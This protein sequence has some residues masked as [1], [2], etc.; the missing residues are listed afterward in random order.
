MKL[1]I[2]NAFLAST[3][4]WLQEM[5]RQNE[6]LGKSM[7]EPCMCCGIIPEN[8]ELL[9]KG[10]MKKNLNSPSSPAPEHREG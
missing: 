8:Q 7:S 10:I 2:L 6:A 3:P 5:K 9:W 1:D 4:Q